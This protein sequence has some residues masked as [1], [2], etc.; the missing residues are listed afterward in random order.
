MTAFV[1]QNPSFAMMDNFNARQNLEDY[2][3][4]RTIDIPGISYFPK[5]MAF[6]AAK[7]SPLA[8]HF[9]HHI[10]VMQGTVDHVSQR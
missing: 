2:I 4:C 7:E 1:E 6:A 10:R 9:N 3:S 5:T 8:L